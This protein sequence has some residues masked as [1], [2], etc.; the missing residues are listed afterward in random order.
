MVKEFLYVNSSFG[1][2][3]EAKKQKKSSVSKPWV[4]GLGAFVSLIALGGLAVAIWNI[5]DSNDKLTKITSGSTPITLEPTVNDYIK[6]YVN[7]DNE[8]AVLQEDIKNLGNMAVTKSSLDSSEVTFT[9]SF[10]G[11]IKNA[12]KRNS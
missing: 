9:D 11:S 8:N 5:I 2:N 3:N 10:F 1:D 12:R 6:S 7:P 4:L